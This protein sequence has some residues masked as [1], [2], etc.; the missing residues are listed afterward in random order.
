MRRWFFIVEVTNLIT[1]G[2]L[3]FSSES[4][5]VAFFICDII[6]LLVVE[7]VQDGN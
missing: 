6:F 4:I 3:G 7:E 5:F 1:K 2:N